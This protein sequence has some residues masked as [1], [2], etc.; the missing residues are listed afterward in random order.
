MRETGI[1]NGNICDVLSGLGHTD[2]LIV[3]DAGFAIPT[4]VRTVDISLGENKP[5]VPEVLAELR[6]HF[7]VEK[8]VMAEETRQTGPTRF[9][10]LEQS[11]GGG[12]PVETIPQTEFR[13]RARS[14][15]A[16]IRTGDFTAYSNILLVSGGGGRWYIERDS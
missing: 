11:F 9:A 8:L 14:V 5:T 7:S 12:I 2:E 16:V 4:G 13:T 1:V 6:K 10:A 15:K 3:C